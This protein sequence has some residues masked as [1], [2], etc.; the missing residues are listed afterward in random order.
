[1]TIMSLALWL[2]TAWTVLRDFAV[3][4]AVLL[5]LLFGVS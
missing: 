5:V 3:A 1:M 4:A 2:D